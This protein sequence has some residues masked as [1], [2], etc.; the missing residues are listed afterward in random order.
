MTGNSAQ[1][2]RSVFLDMFWHFMI[3][4]QWH[5]HSTHRS[6]RQVLFRIDEDRFS[7]G[8]QR[9]ARHRMVLNL[10]NL[11]FMQPSKQSSAPISQLDAWTHNYTYNSGTHSS[12]S[13]KSLL[14]IFKNHHQQSIT[15][16][17]CH[18]RHSKPHMIVN[19]ENLCLRVSKFLMPI[20]DGYQNLCF[21]KK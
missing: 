9:E 13:C 7:L 18:T 5:R 17:R 3:G 8:R 6:F 11:S 14:K 16:I 20:S 2:S 1:T 19:L 4:I 21:I 10:L 15:G 12:Q